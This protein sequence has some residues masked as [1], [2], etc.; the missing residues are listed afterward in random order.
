MNEEQNVPRIFGLDFFRAIAILMVLFSNL[1][2]IYPNLNNKLSQMLI[3]FGFWGVE[4]FFVLSGFLIGNILFKLYIQN[5]FTI[6]SVFSF[7]KRRWFRTLPNYFLVLL[8]NIVI[9]VTFHFQIE[10]VGYYFF[11]FQNFSQPM[12]TFFPESWSLSILEFGYLFTPFALYFLTSL[13]KPKHKSRFFII[14]IAILIVIFVFNKIIYY[15]TTSKTTIEQWNVSLK[16]VVVYRI[17]AILIGIL[18]SWFAL[19]YN[20][21]WIKHKVK[22]FFLGCFF[23]IILFVGVGYLRFFIN[24]CPFFWNVL[25]LPLVSVTFTLFL[26]VFSNWQSVPKWFFRPITLLSLLSYSIYLLHYSIVLQI[27]KS[28]FNISSFSMIQLHIFTFCYL[29]VTFLL[30]FFLYNYFEKPIMNLRNK[31]KN[32]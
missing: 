2:L 29:L 3:L 15:F 13:V 21:F 25:Y 27:M 26:P 7:L 12:L 24:T 22:L 32:N 10:N 1:L 5:D 16:S 4:I 9:A 17:D 28:C 14:V 31:H 8:L 20:E 23:S 18:S 6:Q 11:F 19:S 30:S